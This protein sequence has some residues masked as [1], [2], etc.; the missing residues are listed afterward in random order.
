ML[1]DQVVKERNLVYRWNSK[2]SGPHLKRQKRP[3]NTLD[4]FSSR[5]FKETLVL[6]ESLRL[7]SVTSRPFFWYRKY[8]LR[9][10]EPEL[11]YTLSSGATEWRIR[12][13]RMES[14]QPKPDC[15]R[16]EKPASVVTTRFG[17]SGSN[18]PG[19]VAAKAQR[20]ACC[21]YGA[22]FFSVSGYRL[23]Q[24]ACIVVGYLTYCALNAACNLFSS[25]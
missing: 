10:G 15:L 17:W 14:H 12:I 23:W 6:A 11:Q 18:D 5:C 4:I 2:S 3:A 19:D 25:A 16:E 22:Q 7:H 20:A 8:F 24:G 13:Q 9:P 1:A 21:L